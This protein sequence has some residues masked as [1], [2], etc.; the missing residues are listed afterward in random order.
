M[1]NEKR[2]NRKAGVTLLKVFWI[3]SGSEIISN[4]LKNP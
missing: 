3:S 2:S 1:D 4:A